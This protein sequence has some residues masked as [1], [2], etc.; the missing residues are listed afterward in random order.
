MWMGDTWFITPD[1]N[2]PD[3]T[4]ASNFAYSQIPG[5]LDKDDVIVFYAQPGRKAPTYLW[6]NWDEFPKR[7]EFKVNDPVDNGVS[8]MYIYYND[9]P[10]YN[11]IANSSAVNLGSPDYTDYVS[12]DPD[13]MSVTSDYYQISL[14]EN[15]PSLLDSARMF[16]ETDGQKLLT[17]FNRM[18][19]FAHVTETLVNILHVY[20]P[21]GREGKWYNYP[22]GAGDLDLSELVANMDNPSVLYPGI[23]DDTNYMHT[24]D[25]NAAEQTADRTRYTSPYFGT[26]SFP[27]P[28]NPPG[29]G[30]YG[31][32]GA[33]S[34][35]QN[36]PGQVPG[37]GLGPSYEDWELVGDKRAV[38]DGPCRVIMYVQ[39]WLVGGLYVYLEASQIVVIDDDIEMMFPMLDGPQFYYRRH[40]IAPETTIEL[41]AVDAIVFEVY[42][43]YLLCGSLDANIAA[44]YTLHAAQEWSGSNDQIDQGTPHF[45]WADGMGWSKVGGSL[46][47]LYYQTSYTYLGASVPDGNS[48]SGDYYG[49]GGNPLLN[50]GP[51]NQ[52]AVTPPGGTNVNLPDWLLVT[53]ETHGGFWMHIP[54]REVYEMRDNKGL[55]GTQQNVLFKMYF[56]DDAKREFGICADGAA[57][58]YVTG[59][60]STSP[61]VMMMIYGDFK[62]SDPDIL[63]KGHKMYHQY[64]FP[65]EGDDSGFSPETLPTQFIYESVTP[66]KLIY[67]VGED[68]VIDVDGNV[69]GSDGAQI[70]VDT[71][72][73]RA[74]D[75][76]GTMT[77]LNDGNGRFTHTYTV[78][79]P[80]SA[81][82]YDKLIQLTAT[83]PSWPD[84]VYDL[85][86]TID[87]VAPD[88]PAVLT[89]TLPAEGTSVVLDWSVDAG[90]DI[91]SGQMA[92]PY[93]IEYYELRRRVGSSGPYDTLLA[94][95]PY[96]ATNA[97]Y[98]FNDAFVSD[99]VT[100]NWIV[101]AFDYAGN[102]ADSNVASETMSFP[103][104][105]AQPDALPAT[106][107]PSGGIQIDWTDNPGDP[108]ITQYQVFRSTTLGVMGSSL[109]TGAATTWTDPGPFTEAT[110]YY[111]AVRSTTAGGS[112][113]SAQTVT[114][115]DTIAPV[116]A[117]LATP[118]PDYYSQ[119]NEI[120]VSWAIETLPQ[121]ET[122][123]FPGQDLNGIDH[124]SVYRQVAL[125]GW[126]FVTDV[127]YGPATE[128]QRY[129]D[130]NVVDG[131][132]YDYRIFTHDAAGNNAQCLYDKYTTLHVVGPGV[133][134]P[135]TVVAATDTVMQG[136]DD[137]AVTVTVRNTGATSI[138]LNQVDL[139]LLEDG[140]Y[141]V[142]SEYGDTSIT[143]IGATMNPADENDYVFYVDVT[144]TATIGNIVIDA[145]TTY[146]TSSTM[147]GATLATDSWQVLPDG[148][149]II[150]TVTSS[151]SVV[152]PGDTSIPVTVRI[153]NPGGTQVDIESVALTFSRDDSL[154]VDQVVTSLPVSVT[155]G[156]QDISMT[157]D[158]SQSVTAGPVTVDA[159]ASGTIQGIPVSDTD[160]A[161]TPLDWAVA[162]TA[163]P[164]IIS[165][166]AD[167][168]SYWQSDPATIWVTCD[169]SN[170]ALA[171]VSADLSPLGGGTE[172]ADSV[173]N[174][175]YSIDFTMPGSLTENTYNIQV[176]V[177][178]A[179][180]T[181]SD[182]I[183]LLI[184]DGPSFSGWVQNP[185]DGNVDP[186]TVV[187]IDIE[188]DDN[189]GAANVE[190]ELEYRVDGGSWILRPMTYTG[191][192]HWDVTIPGLASGNYVEYK[193]TATDQLDFV[194]VFEEDYTVNVGS[195]EPGLQDGSQSAYNPGTGAPYN[196]TSGPDLDTVVEYGVTIETT[197]LP[198][199]G[200]YVVLVTI[201]DPARNNWLYI[202]SSVN[203][204]PPSPVDV[205][206]NLIFQTGEISVGTIV[207]GHIYILDDLPSNG[208]TTIAWLP[209]S[210]IIGP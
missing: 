186:L 28:T 113:Y 206:L 104:L 149:L 187:D 133:A 101:R 9:D 50:D 111:Y 58:P 164:V 75:P 54:R 137:Y 69:D 48:G 203:L 140:L 128:D 182:S 129:I 91:G 27:W 17:D 184:G 40:Q 82:P 16:G 18:Y 210:H 146:D 19:A 64:Y 142:T 55:A 93:G 180:G 134:E 52:P 124:Y 153:Q 22:P 150:Q 172:T 127:P 112:L 171:D 165:V 138:T 10:A 1:E 49:H 103:F 34:D 177:T 202:N 36:P 198:G 190:A 119:S 65:L 32:L 147:E 132:R 194:S 157:V 183:D 154:F 155:S 115:I 167:Q 41:P 39:Q 15:N 53:S 24:Y 108:T 45:V 43:V 185:T 84:S 162:T 56:R 109:W 79:T 126:T 11:P 174:G 161:G 191:G 176:D 207:R 85:Y 21:V 68:I 158:V 189:G 145:K 118:L 98:V 159:T 73:I 107:N 121:Y 25:Q 173:S 12:W 44:D 77:P 7:I 90:Y 205:V 135:R 23:P 46:D 35:P 47:P 123:G 78:P 152:Y 76:T 102:S 66:N 141:D 62:E 188:I 59:G 151:Y 89:S 200:T 14:N 144:Q 99:G 175:V 181:T 116:P 26:D 156:Y 29:N 199:P 114:R 67:N 100:Y 122:G 169:T 208:G 6:W 197:D 83:Y 97:S 37:A 143:S 3:A 81:T 74:A 192:T 63:D 160:G 110:Y 72:N 86:V 131:T 51:D 179:T 60:C 95:V 61:Y 106:I 130:T 4:I 96:D 117:E 30:Y 80:D 120:V 163:E 204:A 57:S 170:Y 148:D 92:N 70:D 193:I 13:T 168:A 5:A 196:E 2:H 125:G 136:T 87:T 139:I 31:P 195:Q 71:D 8:W 201:F 42:Y 105:P 94:T 178:N 88:H 209:I 33:R 20:I 166:A 38:I